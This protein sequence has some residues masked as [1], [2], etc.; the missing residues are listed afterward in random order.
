VD[1]VA[2]LLKS[3]SIREISLVE[4]KVSTKL[5][6]QS[7][8]RYRAMRKAKRT[9]KPFT[10]SCTYPL[11]GRQIKRID[12]RRNGP[13]FLPVPYQCFPDMGYGNNREN[14]GHGIA[15]CDDDGACGIDSLKHSWAWLSVYYSFIANFTN[16]RL[17][18]PSYKVLFIMEF[19]MGNQ[20]NVCFNPGVGCRDDARMNAK[21]L[22]LPHGNLRQAQSPT[23]KIGAPYMGSHVFVAQSKPN[24]WIELTRTF[25]EIEAFRVQPP[26]SVEVGSA[27]K[28]V[29]DSVKI[30][31]D[32]QT[33]QTNIIS[34][35]T[36]I[37][38]LR[39]II[40]IADASRESGSPCPAAYHANHD[41]LSI[42]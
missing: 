8:H 17:A 34:D 24:I 35:V 22:C 21:K 10:A 16:M 20:Y 18:S 42:I 5:A 9:E 3:R 25:K 40:A 26:T 12:N 2:H 4:N 33:E 13:H 28:V 30:W 27:G 38:D 36:N 31:A 29:D 37:R 7:G 41:T 32:S 19:C 39:R 14:T 11:T 6:I 1:A 15:W 23:K